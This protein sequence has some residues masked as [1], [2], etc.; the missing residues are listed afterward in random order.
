MRTVSVACLAWG[1][2]VAI[3]VGV[4]QP[5]GVILRVAPPPPNQYRVSDLWKCDITNATPTT[6]T[7]VLRGTVDE[8][9]PS[10]TRIVDTRSRQFDLQ[11]GRTLVSG[12]LLEPFTVTSY[13]RSYFDV[14]VQAG[15][16]PSGEFRGCTEL[17]EVATGRVLAEFC[18]DVTIDNTSQPFLVSPTDNADISERYPVFSWMSATPPRPGRTFLY[19]LQI[20]EQF[21]TQTP[22][23]AAQRN[24]AFLDLPGLRK[25]VCLFPISA[26]PLA[27]GQRYAWRVVAYE[28]RGSELREVGSSEVWSFVA[29][30]SLADNP[31]MN[32]WRTGIGMGEGC[33]TENWDF[34]T[35]TVSCWIPDGE[36]TDVAPISGDHPEYGAVGQHRRYW[37][38]TAGTSGDGLTGE[39]RSPIFTIVSN[40]IRLL[41]GGSVSADACVEL[42]V[43]AMQDDTSTAPRRRLAGLSGTFYVVATTARQDDTAQQEYLRP[44]RWDVSS[45]RNRRAVLLIRDWSRTAHVNVDDVRFYDDEETSR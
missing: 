26:R 4:A 22:Q 29:R 23:D 5:T 6:F 1:M 18:N 12:S 38:S 36:I 43:E 13:N 30:T 41:E 25:T 34:E 45:L 2:L 7:V 8:A 9:A 21:G 24:P 44:H 40:R 28:P 14:V 35:G 37:Y 17:I 42:V 11:P 3:C 20:F 39:L 32:D 27:N 31:T 19:R 10:T 33:A 15:T 16:M